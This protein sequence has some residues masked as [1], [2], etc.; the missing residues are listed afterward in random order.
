VT[1]LGHSTVLIELQGSSLL[2]DPLL[3]DRVAH[4]RRVV[5][6]TT[7]ELD[8]DAV[9]VSHVHWDHLDLGSLK[10]LPR[11]VLIVV[12][13]GAG[14]LLRRRR[15]SNVVEL[16]EGE[17]MRIDGTE[18]RATRAVH[19][20]TGWARRARA[21]AIGFVVEGDRS[22]Y[23]A[24]DTDLFDDMRSLAPH[25]DVALLPVAGWGQRLPPGHL[26]PERAAQA[27][28]LL[29]PAVAIPI[30]WGTYAPITTRRRPGPSGAPDEF[31]RQAARL[32]PAV[33]VRVLQVGES[34]EVA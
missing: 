30:H 28:R 29:S 13:R 33:D 14:P 2:T 15:F 31:R 1:W 3:R 11:E 6:P 9:L 21:P 5:P 19:P 34:T 25:L 4:L 22:V 7:A 10:L 32:A 12:P 20:M 26:D 17:R 23:F 8:V 16:A 18:V 27:L 24:G